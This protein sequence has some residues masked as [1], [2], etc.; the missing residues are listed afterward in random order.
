M[1]QAST[2]VM[3]HVKPE[4][5]DTM[6]VVQDRV[7]LV[8]GGT[9]GIGLASAHL[10]AEEGARVF[11]TGR[12]QQRLDEAVARIGSAATGVISDVSNF[13]DFSAVVEAIRSHGR[14]LDVVFGNAGG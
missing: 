2:N 4:E 12:S 13:A 14:G 11:I 3:N 7:A 9:S 1:H 10:L 5:A 6:G 8:T